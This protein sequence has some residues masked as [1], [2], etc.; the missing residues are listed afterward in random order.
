MAKK[1]K[2]EKEKE[3]EEKKK[4]KAEA[5]EAGGEDDDEKGGGILVFFVAFLI[6]LI[7]LAIIALLIRMDVGGFGSTVLYPFL[8]DVPVINRILPEVEVYEEENKEED[9]YAF[10]SMDEAVARIKE[11]EKQLAKAKKKNKSAKAKT[12]EYAAME[13]ELQK[14]K[15]EEASFEKT[16]QKFYK[17]VVYSD[18]A[19]DINTYKEYYESIEPAN[20]EKLYKQ[21]VADIKDSSQLEEYATTYSTMKATEAAAIFNTMTDNL[22]LVGRI[23]WAMDKDSRGAILGKMDSETAAAVTKIMEP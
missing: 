12:E 17:E 1:T 4:K 6:L 7:W 9:P 22:K 23:L 10:S 13:A 18:K 21:V 3:K 19:P 2:E 11:L 5:R 20:A 15:D 14:Y 8:K 16:K